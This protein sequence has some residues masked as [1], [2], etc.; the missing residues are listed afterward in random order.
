MK[1]KT[2][3]SILKL[4]PDYRFVSRLLSAVKIARIK[5]YMI[6]DKDMEYGEISAENKRQ[7][8]LKYLSAGQRGIKKTEKMAEHI[9][10][11][12][13]VYKNRKDLETIKNDMLFCRLAYGF[14]PDEYL[15][16]G[17][18]NLHKDQRMEW[19][20]DLD[21][22]LYIFAMNNLKDS[23]ILN[24]KARTYEFF[25]K[26]YGR[27]AIG[28]KT[29]KDFVKF[30]KFLNNHP[31]FVKKKV[32]EGM[33]RSVALVKAYDIDA[34]K[35]FSSLISAGEHILEERI[36]QSEVMQTLNASSV[37]TVRCITLNTRDGVIVAYTFLKVGRNG[38]FID[39]GGAGGILAGID[40]ESG[41]IT[42]HGYDEFAN[43]YVVHPESGVIFKGYAFP[44]WD[45]MRGMCCEMAAMIPGV[46][47]IGWDVAL[48]DSGWIVV[49][50]NGMTQFIGPQIVYKRGMKKEVLNMLS[51]VEMI[52]KIP[53]DF[54]RCNKTNI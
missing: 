15:C 49:E 45:E 50:G 47:C 32:S 12:A 40:V 3:E 43:E 28:I 14:E 9:L 29:E 54:I 5:S 33:G 16:F 37:N 46:K 34:Y 8:V 38:S 6:P 25:R 7:V 23:Q 4:C 24:N 44:R 36:K 52:Y 27:E 30:K 53:E 19:I 21:R 18:E 39:N 20:S 42:T 1:A 41:V 35:Y 2:I 48:T 17:L 10:T 11:N 22:Y 31:E 51:K 13:P 26:Y